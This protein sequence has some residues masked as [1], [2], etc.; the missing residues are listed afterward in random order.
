MSLMCIGTLQDEENINF[1]STCDPP[2]E[3]CFDV[4]SQCYSCVQGAIVRLSII[5][6][7]ALM[8]FTKLTTKV[9]LIVKCVQINAVLVLRLIIV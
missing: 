1:V 6:A 9:N 8:V 7:H 5:N 2:C 4:R 3:R